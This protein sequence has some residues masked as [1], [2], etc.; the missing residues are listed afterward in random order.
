MTTRPAIVFLIAISGALAIAAIA[1]APPLRQDAGYHDFADIRPLLGIPNCLN[2][3]SNLPFAIAGAM[4]LAGL[5][6]RAGQRWERYAFALLSGAILLTSV[7]SG[8]YHWAPSNATLFWDRLPMAVG[9]MALFAVVV[10]ERTVAEAGRLLLAPMVA[11]GIASVAWW[12]AY[13]DL[14]FYIVVQFLPLLAIPVM[15]WRTRGAHPG[16]SALVTGLGWYAAAKALELADR[17]VYAALGLSG[18]TLKHLAA[19]MSCW[20]LVRWMRTRAQ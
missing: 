3:L 5:R 13:D 20:W 15:L 4:G 1:L 10:G 19:G 17:P 16:T 12:R 18:H 11:A 8:Y 14:R 7:V 2:V 6:H 9:F